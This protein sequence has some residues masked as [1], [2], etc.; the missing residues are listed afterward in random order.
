LKEHRPL[1]HRL[2]G[3]RTGRLVVRKAVPAAAR[4]RGEARHRTGWGGRVYRGADGWSY[5]PS[6]GWFRAQAAGCDDG[7]C[8]T[9]PLQDRH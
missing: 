5:G 3:S 2:G 6:Y 8:A 4:W 7:S 1:A 9:G